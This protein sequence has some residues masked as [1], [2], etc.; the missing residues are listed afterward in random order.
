MR[1]SSRTSRS[2]AWTG[3]KRRVRF[4]RVEAGAD[5]ALG[6]DVEAAADVVEHFRR[7]GGRERQGALGAAELPEGGQLQVVG[8]EVVAP[9]GDAVGLVHR[10]ERHLH[11]GDRLPEAL[12]VEALGRH[13]E[14]AH[15]ALADVVH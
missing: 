9:F 15:G 4:S 2:A 5:G 8:A 12:V 13:V 6:R 1:S 3:V 14:E 11:P 10:E 7:G